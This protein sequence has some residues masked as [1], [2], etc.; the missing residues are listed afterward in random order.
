MNKQSISASLPLAYV[1]YAV[2]FVSEHIWAVLIGALLT[3]LLELWLW[4]GISSNASSLKEKL[5]L[6]LPYFLI[7]VAAFGLVASINLTVEEIKTLKDTNHIA[8]CS[9]SPIVS[10]TS[11]IGS[12]QGQVL[13]PPNPLLGTAAFGALLSVAFGALAGAK[14]KKWFWQV[15]WAAG[16]LGLLSVVWFISQALYEL[17]AL[18]IYC[19]MTWTVVI[20]TF[21]YLTL[22]AHLQKHIKLPK[23]IASLFEKYH[24][25]LLIS[26]YAVVI[27]L[28][29]F[30]FDYYWNS[31]F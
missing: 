26:M 15:M 25:T 21:V 16:V 4:R 27:L 22:Y 11:S 12:D 23:Q 2:F 3:L 5:N 8:S 14:Y 30:R 17:N 6:L 24:L 20:P 31:L 29:Y 13:G 9:V 1:V 18:C 7:L 10:C 28:I 19:M